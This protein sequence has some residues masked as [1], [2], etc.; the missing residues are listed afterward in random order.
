MALLSKIRI[1]HQR[2][3]H[4]KYFGHNSSRNL[5]S[6]QIVLELVLGL[7]GAPAGTV[8][9]IYSITYFNLQ[10]SSIVDLVFQSMA[11]ICQTIDFY[12]T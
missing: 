5:L 8:G 10:D 7:E 9:S 3:D 6:L 12:Q 11:D 1:A 2:K 4:V